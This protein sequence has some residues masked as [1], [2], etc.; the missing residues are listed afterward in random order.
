MYF[1]LEE[2]WANAKW[3]VRD[4]TTTKIIFTQY[5]QSAQ[6]PIDHRDEHIDKLIDAWGGGE[7][8]RAL[9]VGSL[10]NIPF[11]WLF[12]QDQQFQK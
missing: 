2:I 11:S 8:G 1:S 3:S 6:K 4:C 12:A 7:G 10:K 9:V 5:L